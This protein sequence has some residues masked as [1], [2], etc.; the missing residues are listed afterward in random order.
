MGDKAPVF[1]LNWKLPNQR[2]FYYVV[3]YRSHKW[4]EQWNLKRKSYVETSW[5]ESSM[6]VWKLMHKYIDWE[7]GRFKACVY[8]CV[9]FFCRLSFTSLPLWKCVY[10]CIIHNECSIDDK[11]EIRK[12]IEKEGKGIMFIDK[13]RKCFYVKVH[14][15]N[16]YSL[17]LF[18]SISIT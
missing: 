11:N 7:R 15:S 4:I 14:S 9:L 5:N 17:N 1:V 6:R 10:C 8:L 12:S 3:D 2:Y 18:H 13:N 16:E